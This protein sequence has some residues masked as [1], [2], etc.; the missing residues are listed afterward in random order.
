MSDA[1]NE[2]PSYPV[3]PCDGTGYYPQDGQYHNPNPPYE[4]QEQYAQETTQGYHYPTQ[5]DPDQ[6]APTYQVHSPEMQGLGAMYQGTEPFDPSAG[7]LHPG[8]ETGQLEPYEPR[9]PGENLS[10]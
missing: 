8:T 5:Y 3:A 6:Q 1:Y 10:Y 2:Y 7:T 9:S 4:Y